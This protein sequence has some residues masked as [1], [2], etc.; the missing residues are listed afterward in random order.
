M[1]RCQDV[2]TGPFYVY[3]PERRSW[4]SYRLCTVGR[5]LEYLPGPTT[6]R[7][8]LAVEDSGP[9][10]DYEVLNQPDRSVKN[11][12]RSP[13]KCDRNAINKGGPSP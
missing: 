10:T 7:P 9:C 4:C 8:A 13:V 6:P 2:E 12:D 3:R 1:K 5:A 11:T